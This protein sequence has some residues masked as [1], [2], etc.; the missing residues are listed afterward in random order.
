[1]EGF[2]PP[3]DRILLSKKREVTVFRPPRP[4]SREIDVVLNNGFRKTIDFPLNSANRFARSEAQNLAVSVER[5]A[6]GLTFN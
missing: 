1:M 2:R 3:Q 6:I 5:G 4:A